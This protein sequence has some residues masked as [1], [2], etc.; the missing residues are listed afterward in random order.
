VTGTCDTLT[1][2][3]V[4]TR[5]VTNCPAD[6]VT[7]SNVPCCQ[8]GEWELV[9][10]C[11]ATGKQQ[12]TRS[13]SSLCPGDIPTLDEVDCCFTS[14]W[15]AGTCDIV[16]G[17]SV[18]TRV[19]TNCPVDVVTINTVPC[20]QATEWEPVGTCDATGKQQRSRTVSNLC[21]EDITTIDEIDCCFNSAWVEGECQENGQLT[22][23]RTVSAFCNGAIAEEVIDCIFVPPI[24]STTI[25]AIIT[26]TSASVPA[27]TTLADQDP[28][29]IDPAGILSKPASPSPESK[30]SQSN[31]NS[32]P[33]NNFMI[34]G[35]A[36]F[37]F[38]AG[39]ASIGPSVASAAMPMFGFPNAFS[40]GGNTDGV[41]VI[42]FM[43]MGQPESQMEN[44]IS[45]PAFQPVPIGE[46]A[47]FE[48]MIGNTEGGQ[49]GLL[50]KIAGEDNV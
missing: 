24:V 28:I 26:T 17:I 49:N 46:E 25:D 44:G 15:D 2:N 21:A 41:D 3:A 45:L 14:P 16:A 19:A 35:V 36:S 27:R 22:R 20:C 39:V 42:R 43:N 11:S 9:G 4:Q 8:V 34:Y 33:L 1:G 18:Q 40:G 32:Q 50:N 31:S 37:V 48:N 7:F 47:G 13:I 10:T 6:V 29:V 30:E 5:T 23:T 38:V 12:R